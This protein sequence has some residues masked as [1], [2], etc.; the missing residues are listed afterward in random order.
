MKSY[1]IDTICH[2]CKSKEVF[3]ETVDLDI[4]YNAS[5]Y[6][7]GQLVTN[8]YRHEWCS[9]CNGHGTRIVTRVLLCKNTDPPA[10]EETDYVDKIMRLFRR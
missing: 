7:V 5:E 10:W 4:Y 8:I 3:G 2:S 1:K 6:I 9:Y